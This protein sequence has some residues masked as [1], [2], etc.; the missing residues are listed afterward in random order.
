MRGESSAEDPGRVASLEGVR[1]LVR[2]FRA[3]IDRN[4]A[5]GVPCRA[6]SW[7]YLRAH[8]RLCE[9]LVS[10]LVARASGRQE[11]MRARGSEWVRLLWELEPDLHPVLDV[12][13]YQRTVGRKLGL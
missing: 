2:D 8:G 10:A 6:A 5:S 7:R 1:R 9:S 13:M 12:W 11:E 4:A 3:V